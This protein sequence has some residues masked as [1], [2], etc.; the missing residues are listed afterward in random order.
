MGR[1]Q[2]AAKTSSTKRKEENFGH[3]TSDSI[4]ISFINAEVS[5]N[6]NK[7]LKVLVWVRALVS[8]LLR[9]EIGYEIPEEFWHL[10]DVS[11]NFCNKNLSILMLLRARLSSVLTAP[12]D[13]YALHLLAKINYC[14]LYPTQSE[15]VENHFFFPFG[16][17]DEDAQAHFHCQNEP[18]HMALGMIIWTS[19]KVKFNCSSLCNSKNAFFPPTVPLKALF[20]KALFAWLFPVI[21]FAVPDLSKYLSA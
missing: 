16:A 11:F 18:F 9:C 13:M 4:P 12:I 1:E 8:E 7:A 14:E 21:L 3:K 6:I 10:L 17:R 20:I 15:A 5:P 19:S 2:I